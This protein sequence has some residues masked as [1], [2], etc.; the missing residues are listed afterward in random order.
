MSDKPRLSAEHIAFL[1]S[2]GRELARTTLRRLRNGPAQ[3][4]WPWLYELASSVLQM[5]TR[6][7][8][9]FAVA[10][11]RG[12]KSPVPLRL[13]SKLRLEMSELAGVKVDLYHPRPS[14]GDEPT[15]LY[16]HG[17]GYVTCSPASQRDGIPRFAYAT[18]AR[19]VAPYYRL[20]PEHPFPAALE[21]VL[22]VYRALLRQG[23]SPE[24]LFVAGDSAG[25]GLSLAMMLRLRDEG[26]P[27]PRAAV[28]VSPWV[29]LTLLREAML[30]LAPHDYLG[31]ENLVRFAR[32]YAGMRPLTDPLISP[33]FADL[34]GLPPLLVTSGGAELMLDQH[35]RFVARARAAGVEVKH[36]VE[37]G[38]LHAFPCFAGILPQGR[39]ALASIGA[40]VRAQSVQTARS[41]IEDAAVESADVA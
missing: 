31:P 4:N 2:V 15:L 29:D 20:A 12:Q 32:E 25:A 35:R 7:H 21:D 26:T 13:R 19:T 9:A 39:A 36:E 14:R 41:L 6:E 28:L 1:G 34:S 23:V 3:P 18:G 24:R 16:I 38:M 11:V 8:E 37:P 10:W 17:G 40:F 30:G 27:L 22:T 33:V 5:A